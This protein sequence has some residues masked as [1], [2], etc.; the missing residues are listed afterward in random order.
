MPR[1]LILHA[2][3]PKTGTSAIQKSMERL[4]LEEKIFPVDYPTAFNDLFSYPHKKN[5]STGNAN[6]LAYAMWQF[7]G[8]GK[9]GF[10]LPKVLSAL[11]SSIDKQRDVLLSHEDLQF[12]SAEFMS[13]L[14][15]WCKSFGFE[16]H[17]IFFV[18]EQVGWHIS[19]YNQHVR[20]N[21]FQG[22]YEDIFKV[23]LNGCSWLRTCDKF[24]TAVSRDHFHVKLYERTLMSPTIMHYFWQGFDF[25]VSIFDNEDEVKDNVSM[26]KK[27]LHISE[28]KP[29]MIDFIVDYYKIENEILC[30]K[31]IGKEKLKYFLRNASE[32]GRL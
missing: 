10:D 27:D 14:S 16:M 26:G 21:D 5:I 22:H 31:Y 8:K 6:P 29:E 1:K 20:Q 11:E 32:N 30:Q 12:M 25:D 28:L 4:S 15:D 13:L 3:A 2:G 7:F 19:N 9:W 18:R 23:A 17:I 24:A